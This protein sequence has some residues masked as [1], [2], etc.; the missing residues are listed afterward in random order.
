[1]SDEARAEAERR[2]G[3]SRPAVAA[4]DFTEIKHAAFITGAEWQASRPVTDAE[5][6]AAGEVMY[7]HWHEWGGDD[8]GHRDLMRAALEAARRAPVPKEGD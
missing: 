6:E 1:M 3:R 7:S 4:F 5:V 2:Y 8:Q